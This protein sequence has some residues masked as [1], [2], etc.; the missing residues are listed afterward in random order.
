MQN[1]LIIGGTRNMG[2]DLALRLNSAGHRVTVLNRGIS[3]DELPDNIFRLRADRTDIL[4][5]RRALLAKSF[6]AVVDFVMYNGQDAQS[7]TEI[8]NG[9]IGQYIFISSGQVYLVREDITRPFSEDEYTGRLLPAP[10]EN[11]YAYE[12]WH[13]GIGKREA[14]DVLFA[15]AQNK[16][17]PFTTFRLPMVNSE[18]DQQRRLYSYILR[19]RDGNPLLI[20]ETPNHPLRHIDGAD[21]VRLVQEQIERK[22]AKRD[23]FNLAQDET[24]SMDEFLSLLASLLGTTARLVRA[25]SSELEAGGFMPHCSPFSDRW[26][27]EITNER[28]KAEL[29]AHYTPVAQTLERLVAHFRDNPPPAPTSYK[30][31]QAEVKFAKLV[32]T[33]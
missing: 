13:Y 33:N 12:E 9:M 19:L 1:I 4:Q 6:D 32:S 20:P 30:R 31:R 11:T 23:A 24:L 25:K 27:S 14:E 15:A 22:E 7:V 5:L 10:K 2:Y 8:L 26:M 29:G 3:P 16:K 18:R 17:F 28:S 21:V